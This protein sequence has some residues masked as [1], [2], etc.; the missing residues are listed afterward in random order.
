MFCLEHQLQVL[1]RQPDL[2][3]GWR[4]LPMQVRWGALLTDVIWQLCAKEWRVM[5]ETDAAYISTNATHPLP[6]HAARIWQL[7]PHQHRL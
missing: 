7:Q 6:A 4:H 1:G 5:L 2:P 3:E